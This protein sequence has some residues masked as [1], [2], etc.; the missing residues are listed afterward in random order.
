MIPNLGFKIVQKS[1]ANKFLK[2]ENTQWLEHKK[3]IH[4]YFPL[5]PK[6]GTTR[7]IFNYIPFNVTIHIYIHVEAFINPNP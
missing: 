5:D 4:G 7:L 6:I 1:P 3:N 2:Q